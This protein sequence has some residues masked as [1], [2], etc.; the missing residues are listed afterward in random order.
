[1]ASQTA[2]IAKA[3]AMDGPS[4][5][6]GSRAE[7]LTNVVYGPLARPT[8]LADGLTS[9]SCHWNNFLRPLVTTNSVET[10]PLTAGRSVFA[11]VDQGLDWAIIS[12]ASLMSS[13]L[14]LIAFLLF[15]RQFMQSFM[16][17]VIR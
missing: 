5:E 2:L 16:R 17:A 8:Y 15:Q 13:G 6:P 7:W 10:R 14:L 4:H 12:A 9:V 3:S 1:M 11:S